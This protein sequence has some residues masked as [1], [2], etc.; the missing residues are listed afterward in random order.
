MHRNRQS[1]RRQ[2]HER[3]KDTDNIRE[4]ELEALMLSNERNEFAEEALRIKTESM[5]GVESEWES[6]GKKSLSNQTKRNAAADDRLSL[7]ETY[8]TLVNDIRM[9]DAAIKEL[10]ID[11]SFE[12]RQFNRETNNTADLHDIRS[13]LNSLAKDVHAFAVDSLY[14]MV[15][16]EFETKSQS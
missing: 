15:K 4:M 11:I 8:T 16:Y 6:Y 10:A 1:Q 3:P 14:P 7:D 2:T 5:M 13:S 12:K 9:M